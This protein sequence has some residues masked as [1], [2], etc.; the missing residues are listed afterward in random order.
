MKS[1]KTENSN[2]TIPLPDFVVDNL[3]QHRA[4][5]E[6][7]RALLGA[8]YYDQ[9]LVFCTENGKPILPENF[10]RSFKRILR[11]A[12]IPVTRLHNVRHTFATYLLNQGVSLNVV[13]AL[14]GHSNPAFT[15][16]VYGHTQ[17]RAE[18]E[19]VAKVDNLFNRWQTEQ[20]DYVFTD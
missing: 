12:E 10:T 9:N 20:T 8:A 5:Q 14:L 4:K 18:R 15:A 17:R 7:E 1:P 11:R 2:R 13:S 6:E 16:R 19:A 3:R